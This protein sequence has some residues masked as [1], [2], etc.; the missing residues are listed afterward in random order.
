MA[1]KQPYGIFGKEAFYEKVFCM[2]T[3]AIDT[4]RL[5]QH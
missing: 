3:A 2:D 4:Y 5:P 1:V